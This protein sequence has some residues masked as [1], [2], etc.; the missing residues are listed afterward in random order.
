M[1][2]LQGE[3]GDQL[4]SELAEAKRGGGLSLLSLIFKKLQNA[5]YSRFIMN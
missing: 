1:K 2:R 4:M 3:M 5:V